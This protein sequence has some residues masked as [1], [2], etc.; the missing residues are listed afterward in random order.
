METL[1]RLA[2]ELLRRQPAAFADLV[3][4]QFVEGE[5]PPNPDEPMDPP[6]QGVPNWCFHGNCVDANSRREQMLL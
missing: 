4:G 3:D 6:P 1:Q 5:Q 2:L